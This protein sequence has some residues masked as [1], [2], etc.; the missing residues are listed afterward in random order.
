MVPNDINQRHLKR[1]I[2]YLH[3]AGAGKGIGSSGVTGF[4]EMP[5]VCAENQ[6]QIICK[7][8]KHR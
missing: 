6:T 8:N 5:D 4:C 1:F 2:I 3:V 7:R